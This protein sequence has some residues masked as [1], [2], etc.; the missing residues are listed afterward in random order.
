MAVTRRQ[1]LCLDFDGV[2]HSYTSP[3]AGADK[4]ADGPV[5]GAVKFLVEASKV[6]DV[7]VLSS[8]SHEPGGI[9]AM[10]FAIMGWAC[11]ESLSTLKE[12]DTLRF[13]EDGCTPINFPLHKPPAHLTIDDRALTFTGRWPSLDELLAF[14]PW[15]K[16]E[17]GGLDAERAIQFA[18]SIDDHYDSR[19]F[20]QAWRDGD[21]SEWPEF[22]EGA[23][24]ERR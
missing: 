13:V 21:T 14:K 1:T 18:L 24:R 20:L 10:M 19:E 11:D 16:R 9:S 8:R 7:C 15:N 5:P 4:V 22:G 6:F 12:G 3:W 2:L 17:P 23:Y